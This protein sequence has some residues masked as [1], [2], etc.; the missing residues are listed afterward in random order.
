[1]PGA[2]VAVTLEQGRRATMRL[3]AWT[4]I[5][6]LPVRGCNHE[7]MEV[8]R[9]AMRRGSGVVAH[10]AAHPQQPVR[11]RATPRS[12]HHTELADIGR[13][14]WGTA[15]P[16][17]KGF[18][19]RVLVAS[20]GHTIEVRLPWMMLELLRPVLPPGHGPARRRVRSRPSAPGAS[21]ITTVADNQELRTAGL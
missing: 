16:K 12:K 13:L 11:R 17:Q 8:D 18:D 7:F 6:A 10:A 20:K 5:R 9:E 4:D 14:R 19:D 3:A 15:N 2:D 1:M 21:S